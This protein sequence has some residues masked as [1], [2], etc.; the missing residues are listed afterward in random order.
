MPTK[1]FLLRF[2]LRVDY[3]L[4]SHF[5]EIVHFV[6]IQDIEADFVVFKGVW[7]FEKEPLRITI[8]VDIILK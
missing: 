5:V 2:P 3:D 6:L 4:H 8:C 7:Y 1:I